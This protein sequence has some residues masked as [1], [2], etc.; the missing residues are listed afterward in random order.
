MAVVVMAIV[1]LIVQLVILMT[2]VRVHLM[3]AAFCGLIH[4]L[5]LVI[6]LPERQ[7]INQLKKISLILLIGILTEILVSY[8]ITFE[9]KY[10]TFFVAGIVYL[11]IG[12][13]FQKFRITKTQSLFFLLPLIFVKVFSVSVNSYNYPFIFPFTFIISVLSFVG[14]Y[15]FKVFS[16]YFVLFFLLHFS[17]IY[18]LGFILSPQLIYERQQ[19]A[20]KKYRSI[21]IK[22]WNLLKMDGSKYLF[23]EVKGKVILLNFT[24]N[25]HL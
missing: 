21:Q 6:Y 18:F 4:V 3:V 11:I 16:K 7:M 9:T 19:I 23:D 12:T 17:L 8:T 2:L 24:F 10:I 25:A 22:N 13:L 15:Y 14:G 20:E 5:N 1:F